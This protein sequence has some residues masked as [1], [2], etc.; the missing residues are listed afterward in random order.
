M[1]T[2]RWLLLGAVLLAA[3]LVP[4]VAFE[5]AVTEAVDEYLAS[6]P[7]RLTLAGVTAL[8]MA[9]DVLLPVPSSVV[10]TSAGTLLGLPLGAAASFV[11][12]SLGCGIGYA[13]GAAGR[14]LAA[15][16]VGE[17]QLAVAQRL[18]T[19]RGDAVVAVLRPIPVL[20]EV[21]VVFAGVS[22][23]PRGRFVLFTGLANAGIALA[24]AALGGWAAQVDALPVAVAGSLVLPGLAMLVGRIATREHPVADDT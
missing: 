2:M 7:P 20:A 6:D 9:S 24:Y 3:V 16:I 17:A 19:R 8:A 18:F 14:P 4:F 22:A 12:L 5:A 10:A 21:S 23:M 15:R 11:G 13:V 1:T